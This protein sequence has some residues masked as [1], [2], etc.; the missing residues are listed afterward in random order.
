MKYNF[1]KII[2]RENTNCVK[3]DLRKHFFGTDEVIPMWV[4]DMD[5]A[6]PDFILKAIKKRAEHPILGYSVRSEGYYQSIINWQYNRHNWKIEKDWIVFT[7]GIVPAL[8]LCVR[9]FTKPGEKVIVQPPV[10]FP[11]F[12]A[13][14]N[15]DRIQ[16]DNPLVLKDGRLCIDFG[17]L[18]RKIDKDVRMILLCSPHNPGGSVWKKDEL[19]ELA[20]ICKANDIL[21]ISDEIHCDL[22][23]RP[24][25]HIPM[26][27]LSDEIAER[28]VTCIAPSKTFNLAGMATSS[29]IISNE[30]LRKQ[31]EE[32][33]EKVH[34]GGG[35][36]FGAIAS[37]AA[38]TRGADWRSQLVEYLDG[39]VYN[40][41]R[42][43]REN[44]PQIIPVRPEAT[45]MIWLDCRNL[46]LPFDRINKFFVE[47]AGV[48]FNEG[49]MF[50]AGGE[51]F[52]RM[53]VACP[54]PVL[55][56]ALEQ[57]KVAI[58]EMQ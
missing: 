39:N 10:Y 5:F 15:N 32:E 33:M 45:Y 2:P 1:D 3:Y 50:G 22:V 17:D 36:L 18:K 4:A 20:E 41:I 53:N 8:N 56:K 52:Q 49:A 12:S 19:N 31:F 42:Y 9:A 37:E 43:I 51:G 26:A 47:K 25:R 11:F 21:I 14:K 29:L 55:M 38:Y 23:F 6:T 54:R 58:E 13:I 44:I 34:V 28:T 57:M 24:N 30:K 16:L 48:G 35:N 46:G 7:P 27:C 40:A